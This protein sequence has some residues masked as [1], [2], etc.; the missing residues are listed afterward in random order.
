ML[1]IFIL[2]LMISLSSAYKISNMCILGEMF[3]HIG[4][5]R[6]HNKKE[7]SKRDD[8]QS[9]KKCFKDNKVL[10]LVVCVA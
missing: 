4:V 7:K 2:M 9:E 6:K 3:D 8:K 1:F 10:E 5:S